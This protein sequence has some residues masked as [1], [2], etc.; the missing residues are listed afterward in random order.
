MYKIL[1]NEGI[2]GIMYVYLREIE[3]KQ[4]SHAVDCWYLL[5]WTAIP[6]YLSYLRY[7]KENTNGEQWIET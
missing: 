4:G 5:F 3:T 1:W 6:N 7:N 2:G